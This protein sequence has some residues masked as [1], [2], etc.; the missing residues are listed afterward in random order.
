MS[1]NVQQIFDWNAVIFGGEWMRVECK[2]MGGGEGRAID[3]RDLLSRNK[4]FNYWDF[5]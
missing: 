1:R 4:L 3:T 5:A 2:A